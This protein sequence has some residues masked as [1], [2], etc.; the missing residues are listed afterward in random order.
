MDGWGLTVRGAG[1]PGGV[2]AMV[3]SF[4]CTRA[5]CPPPTAPGHQAHLHCQPHVAGMV[6]HHVTQPPGFCPSGETVSLGKSANGVPGRRAPRSRSAKGVGGGTQASRVGGEA[7][8]GNR[9]TR[10]WKAKAKLPSSVRRTS[11]HVKVFISLDGDG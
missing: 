7:G 4:C 6:L 8:G 1:S 5:P 9:S 10:T 2:S 3:P 11:Q